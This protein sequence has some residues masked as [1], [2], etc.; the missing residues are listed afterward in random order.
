[1]LQ[2]LIVIRGLCK[3]RN[4]DAS[5]D[6]VEQML[7]YSV[8]VTPELKKYLSEVF[9]QKGR[10]AEIKYLFIHRKKMKQGKKELDDG[11]GLAA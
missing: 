4:L 7:R 11:T 1:M 3:E 9:R 6:L 5:L 10:A 2:A 8:G